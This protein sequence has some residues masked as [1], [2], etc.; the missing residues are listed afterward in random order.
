M[1]LM[2]TKTLIILGNWRARTGWPW[3]ILLNCKRIWRITSALKN[4]VSVSKN[5][6]LHVGTLLFLTRSH[7][8]TRETFMANVS[9]T[10]PGLG[11]WPHK[12]GWGLALPVRDPWCA[13]KGRLCTSM[14]QRQSRRLWQECCSPGRLGEGL[15][16]NGE[17]SL[18][19][20][21][22]RERHVCKGAAEKHF[23]AKMRGLAPRRV[24]DKEVHVVPVC[25]SGDFSQWEVNVTGL[26]G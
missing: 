24:H 11:A 22:S 3:T 15:E 10:G 1:H 21:H 25:L 19:W 4:D 23:P 5:T 8:L 18:G 13:N 14:K 7:W 12:D 2:V 6:I 9:H 20:G 17:K 16:K 26:D